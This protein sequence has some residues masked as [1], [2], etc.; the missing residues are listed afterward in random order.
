LIAVMIIILTIGMI[1]DAIFSA[2]ANGVRRRR[3]LGALRL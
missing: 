1:V 2:I 3:G